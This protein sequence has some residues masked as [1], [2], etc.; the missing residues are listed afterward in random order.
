MEVDDTKR[1]SK[2]KRHLSDKH[3]HD[4]DRKSK[5][6]RRDEDGGERK[7]SKHK[8]KDRTKSSSI[9][10]VEDDLGD[11]MWVEQN[12]D[13]DTEQVSACLLFLEAPD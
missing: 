5:K 11:D 4:H 12:V 3:G 10:L 13:M 9:R 2:H 7:H 6:H 8:H 1:S